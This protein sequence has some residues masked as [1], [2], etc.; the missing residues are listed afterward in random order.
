MPGV[1]MPHC[2]APWARKGL[3]KRLAKRIVPQPLDGRHGRTVDLAERHHAGAG[4]LAVD[5]HRAGAA[6][7]GIAADLGAR[8]PQMIAERA[9]QA[10]RGRHREAGGLA[11]D[12]KGCRHR[13][14]SGL[15][16]AIKRL[17]DQMEGGI[18]TIIG[19]GPHIVDRRSGAKSSAVR[20]EDGVMLPA[21]PMSRDSSAVSRI[22]VS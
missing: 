5:E 11:I 17:G 12:R 19:A 8:Q 22:A 20:I 18:A 6:I 2:A 13:H 1:Q 7:A 21:N 10:R 4:L 3:G 9:R 16:G 14:R 15:P